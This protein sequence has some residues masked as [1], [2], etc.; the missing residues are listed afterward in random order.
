M[1]TIISN[2]RFQ[3]G[4]D[5]AAR[6]ERVRREHFGFSDGISQP[7]SRGLTVASD[8]N[9]PDEGEPGQDLIAS[10]EFVLDY[11]LE[12]A[13]AW[14]QR[15]RIRQHQ[16][17]ILQTWNGRTIAPIWSSAAYGRT[18][19]ASGTSQPPRRQSRGNPSIC[20]VPSSSAATSRARRWRAPRMLQRPWP[21]G[22]QHPSRKRKINAF[23][24][25]TDPDGTQ[26]PRTTHIRKTHPRDQQPP[27]EGRGPATAD[28]P[29]GLPFGESFDPGQSTRQ[30]LWSRSSV[31]K[32]PWSVL[33]LLPT[34][35]PGPVRIRAACLGESGLSPE[36]RPRRGPGHLSFICQT[37]VSLPGGAI[38]P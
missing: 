11:P 36:E 18:S 30:P 21:D 10:G 7:G 26:I 3:A 1:L 29:Q 22:P 5:D 12:R 17:R 38:D 15:R 9:K 14:S 20:S 19:R 25:S 16:P 8:P 24:Y 31:P 23:R 33:C 35:D 4:S 27:G 6:R 13:H 32:R 34:V 37:L 2:A 28:S